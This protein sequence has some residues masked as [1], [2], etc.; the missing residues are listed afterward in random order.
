MRRATA[1]LAAALA[2]AGCGDVGG[3]RDGG[4]VVGEALT[5][6]SVLPPGDVAR[7]VIDAEKLALEEARGR[8]GI[9]AVN[10]AAVLLR[11]DDD[12]QVANQARRAIR[13]PQAVAVIGDLDS[14]TA[15][16][17]IPLY[18]A[19]G[20]VHLSPGATY[21]GFVARGEAG[22]PERWSP[23]GRR[24]F[25]PLSPSDDA[26]AVAIAEAARGRVAIETDAAPDA[27]ALADAV[28]ARLGRDRV[29]QDPARAGTIVYAGDD[30]ETL[31]ALLDDAPADVRVLA[32]EQLLR[33]GSTVRDRRLRYLLAA[34]PPTPGFAAAFERR[35]G[36]APGRFAQLGYDAAREVLAAI[37]TAG[38]GGANRRQAIADALLRRDLLS[39]VAE[40]PFRLVR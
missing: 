15:R 19:A 28:S 20:V 33:A 14:E 3:I 35:Y 36:R 38:D 6:Y 31:R 25:I 5:I 34:P 32:P 23:S 9:Y 26:Q 12:L 22:E 37:R 40:R 2:L 8:V 27:R 18:D 11:P 1:A 4:R 21:P 29:T 10:Y 24:T 30:P 39:R 17:T 16:L 7:D 13:D